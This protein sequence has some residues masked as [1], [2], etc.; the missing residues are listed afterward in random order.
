MKSSAAIVDLFVC[1]YGIGN[2]WEA[3]ICTDVGGTPCYLLAL[4]VVCGVQGMIMKIAVLVG[5]GILR[6]ISGI[7]PYSVYLGGALG[8]IVEKHL[9]KSGLSCYGSCMRAC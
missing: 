6:S 7:G 4:K 8:Y 9:N 2:V 5:G 3:G 1:V